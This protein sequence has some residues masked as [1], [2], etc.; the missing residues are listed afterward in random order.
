[1]L[2]I[3]SCSKRLSRCCT[4]S[5][6]KVE[7]IEIPT[8]ITIAEQQFHLETYLYRDYMPSVG[9]KKRGVSAIYYL[10]LDS[11]PETDLKLFVI[12]IK[13]VCDKQTVR[14]TLPDDDRLQMITSNYQGKP[15]LETTLN[16]ELEWEPGT[17]VN[18]TLTMEDEKGNRYMIKA[19][20]QIIKRVS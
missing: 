15:G 18:V 12:E 9:E 3:V 13:M 7:T 6:E 2:T 20:D 16:T 4:G 14:I 8:E 19:D 10:I 1:M 5:E 11:E 17:T